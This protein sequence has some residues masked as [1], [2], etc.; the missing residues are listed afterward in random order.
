M[1]ENT[2]EDYIV[3]SIRLI[4]SYEV[5][6]RAGVLK[7]DTLPQSIIDPLSRN[8]VEDAVHLRHSVSGRGVK[9]DE[10]LAHVLE[11]ALRE[12]NPLIVELG[13]MLIVEPSLKA[14]A[15][16]LQ[17][18]QIKCSRLL[19]TLS[20][21]E[22][23]HYSLSAQLPEEIREMD[24]PFTNYLEANILL[25][26]VTVFPS[27]EGKDTL[28]TLLGQSQKDILKTFYQTVEK[29]RYG[30]VS[31][32]FGQNSESAKLVKGYGCE[33]WYLLTNTCWVAVFFTAYYI[34]VKR[35]LELMPPSRVRLT[36]VWLTCKYQFFHPL[37]NNSLF[38]LITDNN[39]FACGILG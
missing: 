34:R 10:D 30:T 33:D 23:N 2:A 26:Y 39:T 11:A 28:L 13:H 22:K 12:R 36:M 38:H 1:D 17:N 32:V 16:L 29:L 4:E 3:S 7:T 5:R 24:E 20:I 9:V 21:E 15:E 19:E 37:S 18:T 6:A 27:D 25:M 14:L 31:T 8:L 35:C